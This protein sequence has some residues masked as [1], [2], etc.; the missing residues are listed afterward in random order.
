LSVA[1]I[2]L[3]Q[4]N[5]KSWKKKRV[6]SLKF[7]INW[8]FFADRPIQQELLSCS[9]SYYIVHM[10]IISIP[11]YVVAL[12]QYIVQSFCLSRSQSHYSEIHVHTYSSL[13]LS[14]NQTHISFKFVDFP[15]PMYVFHHLS[16][17]NVQNFFYTFAI[18]NGLAGFT[19]WSEKCHDNSSTDIS[20]TYFTSRLQKAIKA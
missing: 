1:Q 4:F 10:Y 8:N 3:N 7:G 13:K 5:G 15:L 12:T 19:S 17:V 2:S 20:S 18:K 6:W 9:W 16:D 14:K 11:K